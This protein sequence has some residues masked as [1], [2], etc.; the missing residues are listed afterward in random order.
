[1]ERSPPKGWQN[2]RLKE[3]DFKEGTCDLNRGRLLGIPPPAGLSGGW[4]VCVD[5]DCPA[6]ISPRAFNSTKNWRDWRQ[7]REIKLPLLLRKQ[8]SAKHL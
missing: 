3:S 1:M 8:P 5:L 7:I 2:L 6:A 4:V